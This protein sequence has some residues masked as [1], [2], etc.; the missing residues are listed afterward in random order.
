MN[1]RLINDIKHKCEYNSGGINQ[2]LLLDIADFKNY[3]FRADGLYDT[4]FVERIKVSKASYIEFDTT[5]ETTFTESLDNGTYKQQLNTVIRTLH[6]DTTRDLLIATK[7][8]YLVVFSSYAGRLYSFGSDAGAQISF[9]QS[10][11]KQGEYEGYAITIEKKSL[12]PLF[13]I[14][15]E[16]LRVDVLGTENKSKYITSQNLE[17]LF[18]IDGYEHQ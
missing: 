12:Y 5:T 14:D 15:M 8:R 16:A 10:T 18:E 4:C 6:A 9:S 7:R 17:N 1:C 2:L 3:V 13:Q 11:G